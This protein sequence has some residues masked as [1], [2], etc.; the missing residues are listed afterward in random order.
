MTHHPKL[1][2]IVDILVNKTNVENGRLFF[3][4]LALYKMAQMASMLRVNVNF[5]GTK[6]IPLNIYALNLAESGFSKGKSI[7]ILEDEI[8][9]LFRKEF[10]NNIYPSI[11]ED[12]LIG[13]AGELALRT[14]LDSAEALKEIKRTYNATAKFQYAFPMSTVEGLRSLRLRFALTKIGATCMETDEIGSV[15]TTPSFMDSLGLYLETY[16]M[17]KGKQKLIKTDSNPDNIHPVPSN[18]L[19]FGTP[20]KLLDG[21][22]TEEKFI[23]LLETGYARRLM[24]GYVKNFEKAKGITAEEMYRQLTDKRTELDIETLAKEFEALADKS[25]Y[26]KTINCP[27]PVA[28][29]ILEYQIA[30]ESRASDMKEHESI[31]KA[32]MQH[33]YWKVLKTAGIFTFVDGLDDITE[34]IVDNAITLVEESGEAFMSMMNR[35]KPY[36]RLAKYV[37]DINRKITQVELVE[38]LPFYK[39]SESS[40]KEIMNLAI[41]YGY[42]NGIIIKKTFT[43]GVEFIHGTKLEETKDDNIICAYSKDITRDFKKPAKATWKELY[44]LVTKEGLHYTAHA[45]KDEY[46]NSENA[47]P[48]FNLLILDIDHGLE[49]EAFKSIMSKYQF[50][51]A[52]TKRHTPENHRYRVIMPMT[53]K[54][55]MNPEEYK[56]FMQNVASWLPFE[57]DE[58]AL[59]IARKWESYPGEYF[60]NEGMKFNCMD[61]IPNTKKSDELRTKLEQLGNLD[62]LQK[63]FVMNI[64]DGS[65]N[66]MLLRYAMAL[67]DR[68][69]PS[70]QIMYSV[71]MLNSELQNPLDEKEIQGTILKTVIK[72]E[73]KR[74]G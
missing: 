65:R 2:E 20:T 42:Q 24:F 27:E 28:V 17:G 73:L 57:I 39:G 34:D 45:F 3:R 66:N 71:Q 67:L 69:I 26:N 48:G 8:F 33:R 74:Q 54:L 12:N 35:D 21:D 55:D 56:A 37:A 63:W 61:F 60:Y 36:V 13:E 19:M 41:A 9:N 5:A 70:E 23:E 32:E 50:L 64:G 68:G 46:R 49:I 53:H 29:K 58:Q 18:L 52:T 72:E 22:G 6:N 40:R 51:L 10:V 11:S 30:C 7:N 25:N 15:L 62:A 47:I 14:G 1:E 59:D 16:D 31:R 44:K 4:V 38:D 43:D